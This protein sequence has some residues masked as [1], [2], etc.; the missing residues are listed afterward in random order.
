VRFLAVIITLTALIALIP[1]NAGADSLVVSKVIEIIPEQELYRIADSPVI[2]GSEIVRC[3]TLDLITGVDYHLDPRKGILRLIHSLEG[4]FLQI[5]YIL[6]PPE[7]T[8]AVYNY[9]EIPAS[10]SVFASLKP[11]KRQWFVQDGKL[12][13]SGS[14][15]FAI[16][17]SDAESFDLKQ[18]LYVNLDGELAKNVNVNAQLSDSQSKLTPEGD[19][20]ELSNLDKVFIRIF[21]KQY[22][23]AMGDLSWNFEGTKYINYQTNIE[24]INAFYRDR[25][26]VQAGYTAA[27]GKSATMKIT[28]IDGKQGP[29]YLKPS[30]IQSTFLIVAGSE[31]IFLD[32]QQLE[33]G[34]DYYI[35]YSEGSVMFRYFIT[36]AN[37]INAY[38]QYTDEYYRQST[39]FNSSSWSVLPGLTLEHHFIH[40][41][42]DK[43]NPLL[44]T[45]TPSDLD[46]LRIAGDRTVWGNG[47]IQV[48]AGTG[49]YLLRTSP[50]GI[51][52]YEYAGTDSTADYNVTFSFVG[53]GNGDYE[54]YS[55][56]KYRYVGAGMGAWLPQKRL[57]PPVQRT[58]TDLA[59]RY[60]YRALELGMEGIYTAD[61]KN[62]LSQL[63]DTNNRGGLLSGYGKLTLGDEGQQTMIK[64]E[65]EKRW[66][67]SYLFSQANPGWRENDFALLDPSDSLNQVLAD[68][69]IST[70][71]W[72]N[73]KPELLL[74]YRDVAD[75]YSQKALRLVSRS[76]G[77]KFLP[78][79]NLQATL[80][81]QDNSAPTAPNSILQYY[82]LNTSWSS[83]I[84]KASLLGNFNSLDYAQTSVSYPGTRYYKINPKL[85]LGGSKTSITEMGFAKDNNSIKI[86]DW[87]TFSSAETYALKH[88]TSTLNHM[89]N[90][91][92]THRETQK[93]GEEAKSRYDLISFRNSDS[94]F[95]QALMLIGNY[96]LNQTEFFPKIR[97]LE[98]VGDGVGLYDSLGVYTPDGDY[99]YNFITSDVGTLTSE[100]NTQLSLY[101][102]PG[103]VYPDW[104][105]LHADVLVTATEQTSEL[106]DWRSYF[107]YPG[108]VFSD[109]TTIF[110][111]QSLNPSLWVDIVANRIQV[112]VSML[113]ERSLDNR[114]QSQSK[115]SQSLKTAELDLKRYWGNNYNI[116]YEN[117]RE[118]DSRYLSDVRYQNLELLVQRNLTASSIVTLNLSGGLEQGTKQGTSDSYDLKSIGC[119]PAFRGSWGNKGRL[120]GSLGLRYNQ[121]TG[122][123][124]L[125]FLPEK[126]DGLSVRWNLSS[127]YR[128][129]SF[130]SINFEYN[131]NSYP[132][133][134]MK[135]SL[136]L[137]FKAEL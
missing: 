135:H 84:L 118:T 123:D 35:D 20:K 1:I 88:S 111:K 98:Y 34:T 68:L 42:D 87:Q 109:S 44:Y 78:E 28:V 48:T 94:F 2:G 74:R 115:T 72:Q 67:N 121:R 7:L 17:F 89:I 31:Q 62:T 104:N 102:K 11:S 99:D 92:L 110:G 36:P 105:R 137:E 70:Q 50:E 107:F 40:Q 128:I 61:D 27:G 52:Y 116:K 18:S 77:K 66:Q 22:E 129:N 120:S 8:A 131:G 130:S 58:N 65:V 59:L 108:T 136:K 10:D 64:A 15:T 25:Q 79:I 125:N 46:S 60:A 122:S 71:R 73:W 97:E 21:G 41:W 81:A 133:D 24:G 85:T 19:S 101:L 103:N 9:Q 3:D 82:N 32:G 83:K 55:N 100:I 134:S 37:D 30:E 117:S 69:S 76:K 114:Y 56:G 43:D 127:I 80:S 16:T 95:K 124:Y 63:D 6:V 132:G 54:E 5:Q 106:N 29:Y 49:S 53:S 33:R 14:K 126:R 91:D 86:N 13:I 39:L 12:L 4:R 96:Q 119:E 93:Q 112:N 38:F 23:I 113:C 26:F 51:E 90:L 75:L 57:L 45:F 47:I